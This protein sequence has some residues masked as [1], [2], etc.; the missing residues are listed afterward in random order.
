MTVNGAAGLD[1]SWRALPDLAVRTFGG[2]VV[3]ANDELFADRQ[4]LLRPEPAAFDESDFGHKGKVYDGWE[5][6]RRREPGQDEAIVRL[7]APGVVHAVVV[8][9]SWFK[10]NYPPQVS[11]EAACVD[12]YP[13]VGELRRQ[14]LWHPIV[15]RSPVAGDAENAFVVGSDRRW[16]H[17]RLTMYPDGGVARLRVHGVVMPDPRLLDAGPVDL[18]AMESGGLV[19]ACSD[20]FYGSASHLLAPGPPRTMGEGWETAR[21]R[22]GG[23]DWV[24]LRLLD[25]GLVTMAELDTTY[26]VGNA[27]GEAAL[28]GCQSLDGDPGPDA[29]WFALLPRTQL[30]PDTRH[31]YVVSGSLP[32][33][34]VRLDIYPDGGMAR[35]RLWGSLTLDGRDRVQRRWLSSGPS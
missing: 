8:D 3:W 11:V 28:H 14:T 25:E 2:S 20:R 32:A 23:N 1:A 34:H 22:D 31:R 17:V 21:R 7:G 16:T 18:A 30:Q 26:F 29:T 35:L 6:R 5:T 24:V 27:P 4:N 10:G 12:G 19:V 9:T 15:P 13:S 33:T